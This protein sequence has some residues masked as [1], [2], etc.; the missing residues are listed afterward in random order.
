V[1]DLIPN[2]HDASYAPIGPRSSDRI[3]S[4]FVNVV[5]FSDWNRIG[6]ME[7]SSNEQSP[8]QQM[9]LH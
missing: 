5:I 3:A 4:G 7:N 8:R 9:D 6:A 2:I 1:Y